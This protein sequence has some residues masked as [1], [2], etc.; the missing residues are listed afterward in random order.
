MSSTIKQPKNLSKRVKW[1]RD[2]YFEGLNRDWNNEYLSYTTGTEWDVQYDE[3]TFYITPEAYAFLQIMKSSHN[4]NA[5]TV[6]L[7]STFFDM[8]LPER[9]AEFLR[10]VMV[11]YVPHDIVDNDLLA[12]G[13]FNVVTSNGWNKKEAKDYNKRVNG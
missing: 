9:K 12:G 8:S 3:T 10:E 2:Y 1:L 7:G 6:K 5:Q 4:Q 11:N 13:R